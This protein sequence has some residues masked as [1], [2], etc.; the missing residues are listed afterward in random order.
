MEPSTVLASLCGAS[1][2]AAGASGSSLAAHSRPTETRGSK[3]VARSARTGGDRGT[4]VAGRVSR[5]C[6]VYTRACGSHS[7]SQGRRPRAAFQ[8]ASPIAQR[9]DRD[10]RRLMLHATPWMNPAPRGLRSSL[11]CQ[12]IVASA[13][14][15]GQGSEGTRIPEPDSRPRLATAQQVCGILQSVASIPRRTRP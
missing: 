10:Q 12:P 14:L 1:L 2:G 15:I 6:A 7:P 13:P 4:A 3:G 11:T 9:D 5:T 8:A